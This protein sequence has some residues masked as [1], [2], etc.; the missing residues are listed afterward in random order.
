L[1]AVILLIYLVRERKEKA[2][3]KI[4]RSID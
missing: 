2:L 4:H 1:G 3:E